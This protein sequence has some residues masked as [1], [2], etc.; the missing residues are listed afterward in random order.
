MKNTGLITATI[1]TLALA[2]PLPANAQ[3]TALTGATIIDGN[4]GGA[5]SRR[6]DRNHRRDDY[7]CR[8]K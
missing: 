1:F 2:L 5:N 4:G 6:R 3:V 7:V 8:T